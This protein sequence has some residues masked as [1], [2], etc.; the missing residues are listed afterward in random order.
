M[1]SP[2]RHGP[3]K[4]MGKGMLVASFILVLIGLTMLFDNILENQFNPNQRPEATINTDGVREV[5]LQRN[6]LGHYVSNGQ[7]NGVP[8]LFLLDTG[9][10]DV[11][12]PYEVAREINLNLGFE[13]R[14]RTA[15]GITSVY[16]TH[17]DELKLGNIV[18]QDIDASIVPDMGGETILLGMSALRE[19][20]FTQSGD[21]LTL[22]QY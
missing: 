14:A 17:I 19:I 10:T 9:A 8:V 7:I 13:G 4:S 2:L 16:D 18:L 12:I 21:T 11:A 15:A 5:A 22:R 1:N 3:G 20:E 6:R